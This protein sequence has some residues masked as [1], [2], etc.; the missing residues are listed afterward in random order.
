MLGVLLFVFKNAKLTFSQE[1]FT[2]ISAAFVGRAYLRSVGLPTQRGYRR[3][4]W[5]AVNMT[6]CF[7]FE[8]FCVSYASLPWFHERPVP[9]QSIALA[10]GSTVFIRDPS[11]DH[12]LRS[13]T[14]T[15]FMLFGLIGFGL[16]AILAIESTAVRVASNRWRACAM[17]AG[18]T[19]ANEY[20]T[21]SFKCYCGVLRP[22]FYAT[23]GWSD[24]EQRCEDGLN[25]SGRV[26]FPSGHSSHSACFAVL[27][28]LHLLRHYSLR[29]A[30]KP[31]TAEDAT[32]RAM[33]LAAPL[34]ALVAAFVAFSRV[35]DNAHHPADVVAGAV[36][37]ATIASISH[38]MAYPDSRPSLQGFDPLG[39]TERI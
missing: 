6:S 29:V 22:N 35:H 26:S 1:V 15:E 28:A 32:A 30:A 34:P 9:G 25:A 21:L 31:A 37:G 24:K 16:V 12:P 36:L 5:L 17:W 4:E 2:L 11:I 23:C 10:D 19:F 39:G 13:N 18:A 14:V 33:R 3:S 7:P 20:L 27:V 8:P 38:Q